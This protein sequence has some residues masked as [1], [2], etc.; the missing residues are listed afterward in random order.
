MLFRSRGSSDKRKGREGSGSA[1]KRTPRSNSRDSRKGKPGATPR[2]TPRDKSSGNGNK[3]N[4]ERSD[5]SD[6]YGW[7]SSAV[8]AQVISGHDADSSDSRNDDAYLSDPFA[9]ISD[10]SNS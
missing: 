1:S 10:S 3:K 8:M 5:N 4:K 7:N 9:E 2:G 6:H